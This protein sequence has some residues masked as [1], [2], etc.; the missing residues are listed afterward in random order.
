MNAFSLAVRK[1][2]LALFVHVPLAAAFAAILR[3]L[4]DTLFHTAMQ[5]VDLWLFCYIALISGTLSV[6][7]YETIQTIVEVHKHAKRIGITFKLAEEVMLGMN[8]NLSKFRTQEE[9]VAYVKELQEIL[10]GF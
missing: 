1:F 9:L 7:V 3:P 2:I 4:A 5:F 10:S 6:V 8:I